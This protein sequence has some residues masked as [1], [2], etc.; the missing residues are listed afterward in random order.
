[1]PPPV[2]VTAG[3]TWQQLLTQREQSSLRVTL[4]MRIT[5]ALFGLPAVWSTARDLEERVGSSTLLLTAAVACAVLLRLLRSPTRVAL[6][7]RAGAVLDSAV[8]VGLVLIWHLILTSPA[9][10]L[11]H[12]L[13]HQLTATTLLLAMVNCAALR[14]AYPAIVAGAGAAL[15]LLLAIL[16]VTDP[17][18]EAYPGGLAR[19]IGHGRGVGDLFL[20]PILILGGGAVLVGVTSAARR[21]VQEVVEREEREHRMREEQLRLILEA[22]MSALGQ[23]VAGV[24]HEVNSPLGAV[25]SS[26]DTAAKALARVREALNID[27]RQQRRLMIDRALETLQRSVE[28]TSRAGERLGDVVKMIDAFVQPDRAERQAVD[29]AL[30]VQNCVEMLAPLRE[31]RVRIETQLEADLVVHGDAG[32]LAQSLTTVI[33]NAIEASDA[34]AVVKIIAT[35]E[36]S[37]AV[38]EVSDTGRGMTARQVD[39]L[40]QVDFT[41]GARVRVRF[42]LPAC[43]SVIHSHGGEIAV[44]SEPGAGTTVRIRLPLAQRGSS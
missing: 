33:K 15:H 1:L 44:T 29:L 9:N 43:Q 2:S 40:F 24:E 22:R 42:G 28:L 4:W 34:S 21:T 10:P 7:G 3:P 41:Q 13:G 14:P 17:R 18:L 25:R 39:E 32:R 37:E 35:R 19:A 20:T 12:L 11:I 26:A 30:C 6:V 36:Q 27:D 5:I 8:L 23:I 16:A 38:I 31:S